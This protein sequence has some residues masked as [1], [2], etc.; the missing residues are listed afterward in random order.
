[1]GR[2]GI[3]VNAVCP[4]IIP[5]DMSAGI[6]NKGAEGLLAEIPLGRFGESPE[7][8]ELVVFLGS[9]RA[10]YITGQVISVDGGMG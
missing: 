9:A 1:M 8:A 4:G 3:R 6:I 2:F 10:G 5:T 7:V